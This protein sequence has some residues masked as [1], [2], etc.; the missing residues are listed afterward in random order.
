[1]KTQWETLDYYRRHR[2]VV[3]CDLASGLKS[4]SLCLMIGSGVSKKLNLPLWY[5]LVAYCCQRA[6]TPVD[7]SDINSDTSGD[8]LLLR[9]QTVR[10]TF[11][12]NDV[13][14]LKVVSSALYQNWANPSIATAPELMRAIGVLAMG[15]ARGRIKTLVNFNFDS[16]LEWYLTFHG[17]VVQVIENV[18]RGL[19]DSDVQIFHPHGY[20][21]FDDSLGR[22]SRMILFDKKEMEDRIADRNDSWT[23]VFRYILGSQVFL[24]VGLSGKDPMVNLM[25]AAADR[26]R[27][28]G[29]SRPIGFWFLKK[30]SLDSDHMNNLQGKGVVLVE[31][32]SHDEIANM[33]FQIGRKAAGTVIV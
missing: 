4:G 25:I 6:P 32:S 8:E 28:P 7:A 31:T 30:G 5:E 19:F 26:Q 23:D 13:E 1:M 3:I 18:P 10:N 21:P 9:M 29:D 22:R 27:L 20:L 14:Y 17:Y 15:S 2:D 16:L 12:G 11:S 24:A 33:L